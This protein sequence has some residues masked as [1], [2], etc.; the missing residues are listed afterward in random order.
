VQVEIDLTTVPNIAALSGAAVIILVTVSLIVTLLVKRL[1]IVS[2]GPIKLEQHNQ[3]TMHDMN[4]KIRDLDDL[5]RKNMR[6]ITG[7]IRKS[8]N[9]IFREYRICTMARVALSSVIQF[10]LFESVSNNHFTTELMPENYDAY[11]SRI[12]CA[13]KDEYISLSYASDDT[14]CKE[15]TLPAWDD[16]NGKIIACID[17]WLNRVGREVKMTCERKKSVYEKYLGIFT[18]AK[19]EW[20]IGVVKQC[21]AKNE[22]YIVVLATRLREER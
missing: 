5:C 4:E 19:D 6:N 7:S 15:G 10:P 22:R 16:I 1:G 17:A 3:G 11:R 8:M 2:I 14:N 18:E 12:I 13:M 9:G 20:R 21:I